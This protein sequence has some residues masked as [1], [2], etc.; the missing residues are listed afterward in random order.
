MTT[1]IPDDER[2]TVFLVNREPGLIVHYGPPLVPLCR[3]GG[4]ERPWF[5]S[6]FV[7]DVTCKR[8]IRIFSPSKKP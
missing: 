3:I 1:T 5:T 8:C 4:L 2:S 7:E 6:W